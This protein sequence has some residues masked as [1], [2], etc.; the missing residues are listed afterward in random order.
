[1]AWIGR[2]L[3]RVR[4]RAPRGVTLSSASGTFSATVT[5]RLDQAVTV[6]LRT[7]SLGDV[8]VEPSEAIE[9]AAG[10]RQTILLDADTTSPGVQ[11][12]RVVVTD[13][14]GT[15]LGAAQRVA[16]RSAQVS[17]VIWLILGVGVGLLFL[18]IAIRLVRRI[19]SER[20]PA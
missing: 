12:A 8:E 6:W 9:L 1:M 11:Y 2:R 17:G 20:A 4:I 7:D 15:P 5:N 14:D 19:R 18:A 13:E 3:E 10:S 16:I